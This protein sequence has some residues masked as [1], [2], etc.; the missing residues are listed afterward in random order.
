MQHRARFESFVNRLS[1][2]RQVL[3]LKRETTISLFY[4]L[5]SKMFA[6]EKLNFE[7]WQL[8]NLVIGNLELWYLVICNLII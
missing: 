3:L 2:V 4:S 7:I 5:H 6:A 1:P 8:E